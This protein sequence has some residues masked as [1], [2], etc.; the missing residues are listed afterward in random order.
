MLM[1]KLIESPEVK[2]LHFYHFGDFCG[3]A[4]KINV[5][6]AEQKINFQQKSFEENEPGISS[7]SAFLA[8][9][10]A[11]QDVISVHSDM[12]IR[13][14]GTA[15]QYNAPWNLQRICQRFYPLNSKQVY[16]Y[17][18]RAGA[19]VDVYVIDSGI[20]LSHPEYEGRAM[21]GINLS[22]EPDEPQDVNGHGKP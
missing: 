7:T 22:G 4:L 16:V 17:D 21:L 3:Y 18:D 15:I 13:I 2:L 12:L 6:T 11:H 5:T 20:L 9:V 1:E 8:A 19:G 14:A 10:R